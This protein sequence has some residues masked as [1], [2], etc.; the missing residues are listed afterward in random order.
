MELT[1]IRTDDEL[2]HLSLVGRLDLPGVQ[3]VELKFLAYTA[4]RKK[5]SVVD[6][7]GVTFVS[8]MGMRMLLSA[9]KN[10]KPAGAKLVVLNPGEVVEEALRTAGL[11]TIVLISKDL[12]EATRLAS[13][14]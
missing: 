10:L 7:A 14:K 1:V 2:T 11:D 12:G 8:S 5:P 13:G 4:S 6:M 3:A 9:A